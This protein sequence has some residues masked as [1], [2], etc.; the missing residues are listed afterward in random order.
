MSYIYLTRANTQALPLAIACI[1]LKVCKTT[2][3]LPNNPPKL[4][5]VFQ[6]FN[7]CQEI[8]QSDVDWQI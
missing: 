7:N 4:Y 1:L 6:A 3:L 8:T 2:I 5:G